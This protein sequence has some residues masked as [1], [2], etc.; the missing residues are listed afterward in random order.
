MIPIKLGVKANGKARCKQEAAAVSIVDFNGN[1]THKI[2]IKHDVAKIHLTKEVKRITGFKE[3][4]FKNG[5]NIKDVREELHELF[6]NKLLILIGAGSDFEALGMR[7]GMYDVFDLHEYY[8]KDS[9]KIGLRSLVCHYF[10]VDIQKGI[11]DPDTDA[12]YTMKHIFSEN[13][14]YLKN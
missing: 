4:T 10:Q 13:S 12:K 8:Q 3:D 14:I 1:V 9:G 6:K 5:K 7:K 11:H 2:Q